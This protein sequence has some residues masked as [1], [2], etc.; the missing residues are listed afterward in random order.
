MNTHTTNAPRR[1]LRNASR[2]GLVALSTL[3]AGVPAAL[4]DTGGATYTLQCGT[5]TYTVVKSNENSATYTNGTT[6][7]IT[8]IGAIL[9][10]G[11]AQPNAV[12][13]TIN[14]F[15]PVPFLITPSH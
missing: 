11:S 15:G 2:A 6:E 9:A 5:N 8:A 10:G 13:C 7:F 4:G 12:P 3:L 14:G 1:R